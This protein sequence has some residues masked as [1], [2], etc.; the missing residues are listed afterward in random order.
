MTRTYDHPDGDEGEKRKDILG[1]SHHP[2]Q[3]P[4]DHFQLLAMYPSPFN[5]PFFPRLLRSG[6]E[7]GRKNGERT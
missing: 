6:S 3:P 1:L 2:T 5:F 4:G 7:T